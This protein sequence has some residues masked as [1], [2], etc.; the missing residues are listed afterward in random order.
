MNAGIITINFTTKAVEG[1]G[2]I[3]NRQAGYIGN[4]SENKRKLV[5]SLLK[6]SSYPIY[7]E[8][9]GENDKEE[10][11]VNLF[12]A[13]DTNEPNHILDLVAPK[14]LMMKGVFKQDGFLIIG[15][16]MV[17]IESGSQSSR[18]CLLSLGFQLGSTGT[19]PKFLSENILKAIKELPDAK[20][21][22]DLVAKRIQ[23]WDVYLGLLE[24]KALEQSAT[25][26]YNGHRISENMRYLFLTIPDTIDRLK[27]KKLRGSTV[28]VGFTLEEDEDLDL[29]REI[30]KLVYIDWDNQVLKIDLIEEQR[31]FVQSN[32]FNLPEEGY[33]HLTRMGELVQTR[34]LKGGLRKLITGKAKN[35]N[36]EN[37][38]FD[39]EIVVGLNENPIMFNEEQLLQK[40]LNEYQ[41][42]AVRKALEAK[43][44]FLIQG[45]PGTG[46]TTVIAEICYQNAMNGLKTLIASQS[47]LAVDNALS[48]LVHDPNIRALRK[49]NMNRVETEGISF[50]EDRVISTWMKKTSESCLQE[51]EKFVKQEE[52]LSIQEEQIVAKLSLIESELRKSR[53]K[54]TKFKNEIEEVKDKEN[55]NKQQGLSIQFLLRQLEE[56]LRTENI[57]TKELVD[58]FENVRRKKQETFVKV[59]H[60]KKLLEKHSEEKTE[61]ERHLQL[62]EHLIVKRKKLE[63][64]DQQMLSLQT[65]LNTH[66]VQLQEI[67]KTSRVLHQLAVESKKHSSYIFDP[68]EA[69][70]ILPLAKRIAEVSPSTDRAIGIKLSSYEIEVSKFEKKLQDK[71]RYEQHRQTLTSL[72][73]LL[74]EEL[75]AYSIN[76]ELM[77]GNEMESL[78]PTDQQVQS[79][80]ERCHS[81]LLNRPSAF[82]KLFGGLGKWK[83]G[84]YEVGRQVF[85]ISNLIETTFDEIHQQEQRYDSLVHEQIRF[86]QETYP[87]LLNVLTADLNYV[88]GS[89]R[90]L[91]ETYQSIK[92]NHD[93]LQ[94]E[95]FDLI[96]TIDIPYQKT[97]SIAFE[98]RMKVCQEQIKSL[99]SRVVEL[100]SEYQ[101]EFNK[102]STLFLSVEAEYN[103]AN[104]NLEFQNQK[105]R[106]LE[107]NEEVYKQQLKELD[108]RKTELTKE[109]RQLEVNIQEELT[110]QENIKDEKETL[111]VEKRNLEQLK[112][113]LFVKSEL[114]DDW[115]LQ[116]NHQDQS[117]QE[118]LKQ[119]YINSANVI[120]ITCVQSGSRAFS[121]NYPDFDVVIIDEVSKATPPEILLPMLKG[122]KIILVGDHNQLPPMIGDDT[123]KEVIDK[124]QF[125]EEEKVEM[126]D[127][128]KES[129]FER[130]F[131]LFPVE[132]KETLR[133]QYRMHTQ[134]MNTINQFYQNEEGLGLEPGLK[135]EDVERDHGINGEIIKRDN[136]ILWMDAP[137]H[138]SHYEKRAEGGTSLYNE[139]EIKAIQYLLSEINEAMA[140]KKE[141]GE[142]DESAK[143][144]IG[145][146]SFYGE[147]VKRLDDMVSEDMY[148]Y[149][150]LSFR[151][152]TVDRFQGMERDII[153]ASFVRNNKDGDIGFAKEYKRVNVALSRAREL[154][155]ITGCSE[156]FCERSHKR[157]PEAALMYKN[158]LREVENASG[159]VDLL[160]RSLSLQ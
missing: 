150:H 119:I 134:I 48:K 132:L 126:K 4:Y 90:E 114:M 135:N 22:K 92:T 34:R 128:L 17:S 10:Q 65:L 89:K 1:F 12:F 96:K 95:R 79:L 31:E 151:I 71:S 30:G 42:N 115:I 81:L 88:N 66:R 11:Y 72:K 47:N 51:K 107:S 106:E 148:L 118:G 74:I 85:A 13:F 144:N 146:I 26:E 76:L 14:T 145:I 117:S 63:E 5:E 108:R 50:T 84:L 101:M 33:L 40:N 62:L 53:R 59:N 155:V 103:A 136:H 158:I 125:S 36:I 127:Y 80:K 75:K 16:E 24:S 41:R 160:G 149:P 93:Q 61:K 8:N 133:V 131:K 56:D 7:V 83:K 38:L 121:D 29:F 141:T 124:G 154:L 116:L 123:L 129:L 143:K 18:N 37:L 120:G 25:V 57:Y 69:S 137:L 28:K 6:E 3:L 87:T 139:S 153:I 70:R 157:N 98:Q 109:I 20:Q 111:K 44:I 64:L 152:G 100:E 23:N 39:D 60:M 54:V 58:V 102:T 105:V 156:L 27:Q 49:G 19:A 113:Q 15:L 35:P 55:E 138:P 46:K 2:E 9:A 104:Q 130:L 67:D 142:L 110:N 82:S 45:P 32:E 91:E 86:L 140:K 97:S 77:V 52:Q 78:F 43:D 147:Q 21:Q 73:T 112:N 122:K 94:E 159:R 99:N 68:E